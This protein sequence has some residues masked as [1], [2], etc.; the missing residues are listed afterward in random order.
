MKFVLYMFL[1]LFWFIA[2]VWLLI[3]W[4]NT[5][6]AKKEAESLLEQLGA[7]AALLSRQFDEL[8][9]D[10]A[11]L[12]RQFDDET[13]KLTQE[14]T[15]LKKK[16]SAAD[17]E[18][19]SLKIYRVIQD[20]EKHVLAAE[21]K[22]KERL[23]AANAAAMKLIA[24]AKAELARANKEGRERRAK[25]EEDASKKQA[26]AEALLESAA[27]DAHAIISRSKE[28]AEK[29]AGDAY[30]AL[31]RETELREAVDA[32]ERRL[33]GYDKNQFVVPLYS[34]LDELAAEFGF[35][36]AGKALE[37]A[38]SVTRSMVLTKRAAT[39]GYSETNRRE[40]AIAFVLDAF[41]GKV[42]S[43]LA[44]GKKDNVGT[45]ER[46]IRDAYA[47]VN[48]LGS[49]FRVTRILPE[50]L[51]ARIHELQ[52]A[53]VVRALKEQERE[54]QRRLREMMREEERA[55][56]EYERAMKEAAKEEEAIRKAIEKIQAQAAE[57]NEVQRGEFEAKLRDMETKLAEAEAKNQRAVSMAQQT[58]I[59]HV[60]V[61]SNIGSF[62][63]D[64]F[65]I[66]M[67]RRL[68]PLDRVRELGD[69]S[70]PFEFDVHAILYSEDAPALE[71]ALH[72]SFLRLQMNKV[73]P[74]K[75]FFRVTLEDIKREVEVHGIEAQWTMVAEAQ[76]WRET[77]RIEE[78]M[79]KSADATRRWET[80]QHELEESAEALDTG[81]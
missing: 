57:A 2:T 4:I 15:Q 29:I 77:L 8:G 21:E 68:D 48:E 26:K 54:E 10:A 42:D 12:S 44:R 31:E 58:R 76:S 39:S 79:R 22:A 27:H 23:A 59:G 25:A 53:A 7:D 66:G 16:L 18:I 38:R 80:Y 67:T 46:E 9:D 5:S 6:K 49:A 40:T 33:K 63:E 65:K 69:A 55:R 74:R 34:V 50:Y 51:E 30:R 17:E 60:Y 28:Q 64:V 3:A 14:I 24:D 20:V 72:H 36:D 43:I 41:N 45:L 61:I 78:E 56:K 35:K 11:R 75:E 37:H 19:S 47:L 52:A 62:G 32:M 13:A 1:L 73:N 70:V 81:D 71:R